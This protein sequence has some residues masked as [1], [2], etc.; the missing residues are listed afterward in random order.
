MES[1]TPIVFLI[2]ISVAVFLLV[3]NLMIP[4]FGSERKAAKRLKKRLSRISAKEHRPSASKMLREKYLRN[5]NPLERNL[6]MLPGMERLALLIEQSGR[7]TPAH[8]LMLL[9]VSMGLAIGGLTWFF[10]NN[11]LIGL[12]AGVLVLAIPFLKINMD[13]SKRMAK[14][15]EQLPEAMDIMVRALKA[16]H[17]FTGTLRLVA[18]EM[19]EPI[20]KEFGITFSDI[21][22]GLDVKQ[23]FLN[24]LERIPNMTLMTLVIA[25]IV[26]RETGGNLAETLA[27]ISA[28]IRG[29]FRFQRKV[30][31]LSA[32]GRMSAWILVLIPFILFVG[33]MVTTPSYLTIMIE[34]P[35]GIK[36]ISVAF[37][38]VVIGIFWLRRIIRIEV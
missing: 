34:D 28:V 25:V 14:F 35:K 12:L 23:A 15:E 3:W 17:P 13:R 26:Q 33:L 21:N 2:M 8:R 5:L 19:N 29:R 27:N 6:E 20:S 31:T 30:T 10:T 24:M 38:M 4:V 22:Y 9:S 1:N 32:E 36:I 7:N 18:E 16:G 37:T 11:L